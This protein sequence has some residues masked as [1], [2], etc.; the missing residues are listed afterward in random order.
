MASFIHL[1]IYSCDISLD[2]QRVINQNVA[3]TKSKK[4]G[5]VLRVSQRIARNFLPLSPQNRQ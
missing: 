3:Q 5:A 2:S 1:F 4:Q